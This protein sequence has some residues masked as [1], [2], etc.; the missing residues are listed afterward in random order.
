M[1]RLRELLNLLN[2]AGWDSRAL[3]DDR[4][5]HLMA[6]GHTLL[7]QQ[8]ISGVHIRAQEDAEWIEAEI[9]VTAG[10]EVANP[11][12]LCFGMLQRYGTQR[13][14]MSIQLKDHSRASFIAH[15]LFTNVEF[16]VHQ[17]EE[18]VNVGKGAE[19]RYTEAHYHGL[20]GGI[21]VLP[22]VK[23]AVGP[24]GRYFS[25]FSLT[26]GRVG[27]LDMDYQVES[28]AHSVTEMTSRVFGHV[29][30]EI[31]I[32]ERVTLSG[33]GARSLIKSRVVLENEAHAKV[34]S[35]TEGNAEATR[36]HM[37]C[38]EILKDQAVA[39]SIPIVRVSHPLAKITH[40]A[41]IGTVDKK[42]METLM[43]RGL[44]PEEAV[45]VIVKG[46]LL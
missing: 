10:T 4:V 29:T 19:M 41:A 9:T 44:T 45:D 46:L 25:N 24:Q 33:H 40:E 20:S 26:N 23:V 12:H 32:K 7:S 2:T 6:D 13:V 37:D 16:G 38:M 8:G 39:E 21:Q 18:T 22:R 30:D 1:S 34:I 14:R 11:I 28:D 15:C 43:S 42:Q 31:R 5:A 35:I 17:M 3:S 27:K 36:G